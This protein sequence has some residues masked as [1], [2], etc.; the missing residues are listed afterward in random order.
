MNRI[1]LGCSIFAVGLLGAGSALSAPGE[2]RF[3]IAIADI[4]ARQEARM[5]ALDADD[6]G[7]VDMAEFEAAKH[8]RRGGVNHR[9]RGMRAHGAGGEGLL[10]AVEAELFDLLDTNGDGALS[11]QEHASTTHEI[12]QLARKRAMFK[13]LDGNQDGTLSTDELPNPAAR[14]AAADSNSDGNITKAEMRAHHK[15][16]RDEHGA[17]QGD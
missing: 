15:S 8:E 17:K 9:R 3:P 6:D 5:Q 12:R 4:E 13:H 7:K 11:R 10:K 1:V 2:D 16:H 14:L